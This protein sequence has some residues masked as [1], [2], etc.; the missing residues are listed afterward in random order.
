MQNRA[1]KVVKS[2]AYKCFVRKCIDRSIKLN[3][4]LNFELICTKLS[5][6]L[7]PVQ[8]TIIILLP[9]LSNDVAIAASYE[10]IPKEINLSEVCNCV[11]VI[12]L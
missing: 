12:V 11:L 8:S 1:Q 3:W 7:C 9:L 6:F 10:T 2:F 5:I 4:V